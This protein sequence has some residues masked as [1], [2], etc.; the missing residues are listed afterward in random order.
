[1]IARRVECFFLDVLI[2]ARGG[3]FR[4]AMVEFHMGIFY[5]GIAFLRGRRQRNSGNRG[6]FDSFR[7]IRKFD[8]NQV[9]FTC[10]LGYPCGG[11]PEI[12]ADEDEA[13]PGYALRVLVDIG[14][15]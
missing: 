7:E 12:S 10:V 4:A 5:S 2:L 9:V 15:L 13:L 14:H 1:M 11:F 6:H 3:D 8:E